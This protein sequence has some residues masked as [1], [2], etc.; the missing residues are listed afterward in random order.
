MNGESIYIFN[1]EVLGGGSPL[2]VKSI[3]LL[4]LPVF[5]IR[6]T[7]SLENKGSSLLMSLPVTPLNSLNVSILSPRIVV[8]KY[9]S[10]SVS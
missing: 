9:K 3:Y 4:F 5:F 10:R 1:I 8:S 7:G 2:Y 6:K